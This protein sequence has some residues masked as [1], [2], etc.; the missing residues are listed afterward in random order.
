VRERTVTRSGHTF[1]VVDD[2]PAWPDGHVNNVDFW[3]LYE[4]GV[5]E[6]ELDA[7]LAD[8]LRPHSTF[9][10]IGAWTGPVTLLA[11]RLCD[12]VFAV[13]PDPAAANRFRAN[14]RA[15]RIGNVTLCRCAIGAGSSTVTVGHSPGGGWGDSMTS[16]HHGGDDALTVPAHTL[17]GLFEAYD[18]TN[19]GLI[20]M[21]VE[22]AEADILAEAQQFLTALRAPLLVSLHQPLHPDPGRYNQ[23][24]RQAL[25]PFTVKFLDGT[26]T[27]LATVLVTP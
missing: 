3:S 23:T 26:W 21:D 9:V 22:G 16:I 8:H 17:R 25:A 1:T 11:A 20:K 15:S 10:D 7:V 4:A 5:W 2:F 12:H 24:I 13:E 19:P 18:I 27:S 14:M 6:P